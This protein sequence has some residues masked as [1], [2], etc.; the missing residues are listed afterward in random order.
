MPLQ[1]IAIKPSPT[2]AVALWL[3]HMAA[4]GAIWFAALPSWLTGGLIAAISSGFAW[5]LIGRAMLRRPRAIVALEITESGRIAFL[6]RSGTWHASGLLGTSFVSPRLTI[7]N[8]K[9]A[10]SRLA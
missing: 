9:A 2:L 5:S 1:R 10:Q 6:T 3:A 8:L 4:A 7:L